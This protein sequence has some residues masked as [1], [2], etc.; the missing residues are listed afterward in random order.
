[1]DRIDVAEL[2]PRLREFF[3]GLFGFIADERQEEATR[4]LA[5]FLDGGGN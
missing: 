3:D 5:E 1:M 2:S 4:W